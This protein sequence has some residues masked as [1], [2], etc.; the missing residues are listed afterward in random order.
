METMNPAQARVQLANLI[1]KGSKNDSIGVDVREESDKDINRKAINAFVT[2]VAEGHGTEAG[3][4]ALDHLKIHLDNGLP[5]SMREAKQIV[6]ECT[7]PSTNRIALEKEALKHVAPGFHDQARQFFKQGVE[8]L[9]L[10]RDTVLTREQL[11]KRVTPLLEDL[12]ALQGKGRRPLPTSGQMTEWAGLPEDDTRVLGVTVKKSEQYKAILAKLD[13]IHQ[14]RQ[15]V[16]SSTQPSVEI[17]ALGQKLYELQLALENY[18]ENRS[19]NRNPQMAALL[20][21]VKSEKSYVD[22]TCSLYVKLATQNPTGRTVYQLVDLTLPVELQTGDGSRP[23][24]ASKPNGVPPENEATSNS[25]GDDALVTLGFG[26]GTSP[27]A[28]EIRKAYVAIAAKNHPDKLAQQDLTDPAEIAKRT[29]KFKAAY[30]AY[31]L[32]L[33]D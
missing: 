2:L 1:G 21:Q 13:Q 28:P 11:E 25:A 4:A 9:G 33:P 20:Q 12:K 22:K 7:I 3:Q 18:G 14:A 27:S 19:H 31:K 32:L 16:A 26:R 30:D 29:E 17:G 23:A 6:S 15:L 10:P 8:R 5:L 24:G